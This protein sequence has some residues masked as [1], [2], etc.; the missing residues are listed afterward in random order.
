M[1]PEMGH[2]RRLVLIPPLLAFTWGLNWP[3]VKIMLTVLPPFL[4]RGLGLGAGALL[5]L[6][7]IGRAHV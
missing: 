2:A 4:L 3:A 7:E 6:G 5:L 1:R